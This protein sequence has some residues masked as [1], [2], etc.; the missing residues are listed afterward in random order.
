[1]FK[2]ILVPTDGSAVAELAIGPAIEFA[3]SQRAR[4]I[5]LAVA[6]P[7]PALSV[8]GTE[9]APPDQR[10]DE[11][12]LLSEARA[13]VDKLVAAAQAADVPCSAVVMVAPRPHEAIVQTA[14]DQ[15]C[16]LIIMASHGRRGIQRLVMGGQTEKVLLSSP[17]PVL[18]YRPQR[19][20]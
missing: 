16:D 18:V 12:R 3:K 9:F 15:Q 6:E 14:R 1:M 13:S 5:A 20:V 7:P 10:V 4:L 19:P 8:P 11:A 17:V 2:T